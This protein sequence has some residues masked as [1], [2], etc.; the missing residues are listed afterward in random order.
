M[1][2][3]ASGQNIY[4]LKTIPVDKDTSFLQQVLQIRNNFENVNECNL[5][6]N[7]L[8]PS[9]QSKGFISASIDSIISDSAQTTI[10]LFTGEQYKWQ[11]MSANE[12][13]RKWL[14]KVGWTTDQLQQNN[15]SEML[16][17]LKARML[18]YFENNGYPFAKIFMD[19]F[20]I[21]NK[22]VSGNINIIPG[23]LYKVDSLVIR[24]NAKISTEYLQQF[25]DLKNGSVYN[26]EKLQKISQEIKKLNYVVEKFPPQFVWRSSGGMVELFLDEKKSSQVNV[27]IGFL[28]NN[29]PLPGAKKLS[30]TGEALLNLKNAFG[31]GETIG[32]VWQKLQAASQQ[33]NLSFQL[34][35]L[36][37][38]PF[39]IDFGFSLL[40]RDSS[41][42][43]FNIK[44]GA[45]ISLSTQQQAKI[46]AERFSSILN[47]IDTT[48]V[49]ATK[50][51]PPEADI[52]ITNL[53]FEYHFNNTNYVFNPV[54]GFEVMFST[55]VG[56]KI[57]KPNNQILELKDPLQ[58]D[59]DFAELYDTIKTKSYQLK[60]VLSFAKYFPLGKN[61]STIKT[62]INGGYLAGS[63][64]FRNELFQI[65]GYRLL[66]GFD[67]QSQYLSRYGIGT[68]EYRYLIGENSYFNCFAD[69]GWG[70]DW[71]KTTKKTYNYLSAGLGLSFETKVGLFNLAWAVGKR[72]DTVFNLRQSKIHFGFINYF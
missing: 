54:S 30:L 26:K 4:K 57:I 33:L 56:N 40:K 31:S 71:S 15:F 46:F 58:P 11:V 52:R 69:G 8:I 70:W 44:L 67:E 2:L 7:Q 14:S 72:N 24:G 27:I 21:N 48:R 61:R 60:S 12:E 66:R 68:V 50:T 39:G 36:F 18:N 51:L 25:L 38:T 43:N 34:P 1:M 45:I 42:L 37:K 47:N 22:E 63:N 41:F 19:G 64:L 55:A 53:G 10:S 49:I 23:P 20:K 32:L 62:A 17:I 9:L 16:P 5:Y 35:Y 6:I 65:G 29:N 3:K 59:F 13:S 28:P